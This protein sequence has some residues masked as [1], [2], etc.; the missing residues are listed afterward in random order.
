M[1]FSKEQFSRTFRAVCLSILA[2]AIIGSA[3]SFTSA[4][5][6]IIELPDAAALPEGKGAWVI[7]Q[8]Y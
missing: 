6:Q 4:G 3:G 7:Y 2:L 5:A 1:C 8:F